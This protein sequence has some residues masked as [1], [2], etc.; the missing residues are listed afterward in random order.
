MDP[1]IN[2]EIHINMDMVW[3]IMVVVDIVNLGQITR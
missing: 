1:Y 3:L 2:I